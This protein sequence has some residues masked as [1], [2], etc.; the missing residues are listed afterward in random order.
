MQPNCSTSGLSRKDAAEPGLFELPTKP[1]AK[2]LD[3]ATALA[4]APFVRGSETSTSTA[5]AVSGERLRGNRE[6]VLRLIRESGR[7][8]L[9]DDEIESRSGRSGNSIRPA[10][11]FLRDQ[12]FIFDSGG[13]RQTRSGQAA[14]VWVVPEFAG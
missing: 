12:N 7:W 6:L 4:P 9:T 8:G 10:R 13:K 5:I 2:N 3:A 1:V 14:V 11:V